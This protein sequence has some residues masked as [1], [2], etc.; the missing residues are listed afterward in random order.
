[1]LVALLV[2]TGASRHLRRLIVTAT[3]YIAE[4][5]PRMFEWLLAAIG[6][7]FLIFLLSPQQLPVSACKISLIAIVGVRWPV[8]PSDGLKS[9][10]DYL[11]ARSRQS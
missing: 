11:P 6:M 1:M 2:L 10:L 9:S 3:N 5:L 4:K 8:L 7:C